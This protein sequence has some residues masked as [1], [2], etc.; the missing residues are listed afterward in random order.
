MYLIFSPK[1]RCWGQGVLEQIPIS[2]AQRMEMPSLVPGEQGRSL[3][4]ICTHLAFSDV[5]EV[6]G[7]GHVCGLYCQTYFAVAYLGLPGNRVFNHF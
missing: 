1:Y 6:D 3:K 4:V 7:V 2:R 5:C